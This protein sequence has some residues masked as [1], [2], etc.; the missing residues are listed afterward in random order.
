MGD[1]FRE[2]LRKRP[3][4]SYSEYMDYVF[5]CVNM[6]LADYI[7]DLKGKYAA[8]HGQYK[9]VMYPDIE[10]AYDLCNDNVLNFIHVAEESVSGAAGNSEED[11]ALDGLDDELKSLLGAFSDSTKTETESTEFTSEDMGAEEMLAFIDA[12]MSVTEAKDYPFYQLCKK[13]NFDHFLV[14]SLLKRRIIQGN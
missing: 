7:N 1:R 2:E 6:R 8:G 11:T 4:D 3:F 10:I 9:N 13:L 14:L 5:A 12:R